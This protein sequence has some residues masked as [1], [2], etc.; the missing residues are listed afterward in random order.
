MEN[1]QMVNGSKMMIETKNLLDEAGAAPRLYR[2]K[3]PRRGQIE[4]EGP[5]QKSGKALGPMI[6]RNRIGQGDEPL[7]H[8]LGLFRKQ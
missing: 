3:R 2:H 8:N 6:Q 1:G 7:F 5:C 4:N